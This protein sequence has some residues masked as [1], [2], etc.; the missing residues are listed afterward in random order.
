[1]KLLDKLFGKTKKEVP[2]PISEEDRQ[3]IANSLLF[4][5]EWYCKEYGYGK[6]LDAAS[7]YLKIGWLEGKNPSKF[8]ST[9]DYQKKNPDVDINP[10]LHFEKFGVKEKRYRAEIENVLPEILA[11]HPDCKTEL[12]DGLLRI[13]ITNA[14]NAKCRYCGVR[15]TFGDEATH[16]MIPSWYYE[17]CKPIYD[18]IGVVLITG[19]D[20]FFAKESFNYMKFMSENF[21]QI[22]LMTES[23]GIAFNEKFQE[24]AMNNLFK[25]HFS[26]NASSADIFA[27]SC[28]DSDDSATAKKMFPLMI[29]N[30][31]NYVEKL[32][33]A[34][35]LCFAPDL[36]MVINKDNV[37]DILSFVELSLELH[38]GFIVFF[39]DYSENDMSKEFFTNP[40]ISRPAMKT[41][42][43]LERV[44]AE[45]IIIY[46]RL[47]TPTGEAAA[48]QQEVEA[49]P[50]DELN[51]KYAKILKMA[52]GRSI[53]GELKRRNEIRRAQGK[54]ELSMVDDISPSLHL[55]QETDREICFA[56]W[57]EIDLYPDGRMDFCGWFEQTLNIKDFIQRD[58]NGKE[59]V[60]WEKILNSFEYASA[61]YRILHDDFRGCQVCCPMNSVKSPVE[62][63]TKYNFDRTR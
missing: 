7:H 12:K 55:R 31:K 26:I 46:F 30:I 27:K 47:W 11:R 23:N 10:L 49:I 51:A 54:K 40:E 14:C 35:K 53:A 21:P 37:D 57:N 43:E 56:P 20:A 6:Y 13:R 52:T 42:M 50:I 63:V 36:S 3:V 48:L 44:L 60:D 25:T 62:A 15:C 19:G 18:K 22:T 33:K 34:D 4:D 17:L 41:L 24:L 32:K 58:D 2:P 59:F 39:F 61:R 9:T 45:K 28:W 38:A 29:R 16:A 8:F 5:S 1:M